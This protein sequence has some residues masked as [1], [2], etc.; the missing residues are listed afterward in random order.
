MPDATHAPAEYVVPKYMPAIDGLR[1]FAVLAVMIVHFP[2]M[3]APRHVLLDRL[4]LQPVTQYG[5][6]GVDLFFVISG[7]LITGIL[8]DSKDSSHYFRNF[9]ARRALRIWPLYYAVLC[10]VFCFYVFGRPHSS[11]AENLKWGWPYYIL[12]IQNFFLFDN[13]V[14]L[15]AV[16]W[17]LAVEEQFYIT[18]PLVVLLCRPGRV[19][20]IVFTLLL[21]SP[22]IRLILDRT[23]GNY[24]TITFG[25]MD[26][27]LFGSLLALW[28]RSETFSLSRLRK[29]AS[30]MLVVGGIASVYLLTTSRNAGQHSILVYSALPVVFAGLVCFAAADSLLPRPVYKFLT[31]PVLSFVGK[32]SYGLYLLHPLAYHTYYF[33]ISKSHLPLDRDTFIQDT[34]AFVG[35]LGLAFLFASA[36]WYFF[37][38]PILR[39]KKKFS[40][41]DRVGALPARVRIA[42]VRAGLETGGLTMSKGNASV[43]GIAGQHHG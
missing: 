25:R 20:S 18:W 42:V 28:F 14:P 41:Y 9:Y 43:R 8:L 27:I 10:A 21:A 30:V 38:Q 2:W 3:A 13:A 24:P 7:F 37:E 1:A 32:I 39:L 6:V 4:H 17:S 33:L 34:V 5:W 22:V 15:L 29:W 36:S 35:E 11:G 26:G 31:N 16:T 19:R 23:V 12:Y 40:K